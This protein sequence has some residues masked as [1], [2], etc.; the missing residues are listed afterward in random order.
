MSSIAETWQGTKSTTYM[1][2]VAYIAIGVGLTLQ[3]SRFANTPSYANLLAFAASQVWGVMYLTVAALLVTWRLSKVR[4]L[5]V[6]SHT[7]GI[8]LTLWWWAAFII[9]YITDNGTTIVNIVSWGVFLF[10]VARSAHWINAE[11]HTE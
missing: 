3:P 9:R 8:V 2:I 5:G 10:L 4:W 11:T 6:T 7:L 1:L